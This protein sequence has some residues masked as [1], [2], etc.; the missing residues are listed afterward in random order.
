MIYK[1]TK[2]KVEYGEK[3]RIWVKK[4]CQL[5]CDC[6]VPDEILCYA[7]ENETTY[8]PE[9]KCECECHLP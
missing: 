1:R 6:V 4:A 5:E 3:P 7:V 2:P 8:N 9:F